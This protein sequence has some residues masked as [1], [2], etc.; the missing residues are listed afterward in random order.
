MHIS[1]KSK[2]TRLHLPCFKS[3]ELSLLESL[4]SIFATPAGVETST[5]NLNFTLVGS[6]IA[7]RTGKR[8][9]LVKKSHKVKMPSQKIS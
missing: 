9:A 2:N 1:V 6:L 5:S 8:V 3:L 7:Y 4:I